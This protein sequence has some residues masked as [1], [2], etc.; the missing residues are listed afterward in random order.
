MPL[1]KQLTFAVMVLSNTC[2]ALAL[3]SRI[4]LQD[5]GDQCNECMLA[6]MLVGKPGSLPAGSNCLFSSACQQARPVDEYSGDGV[7]CAD[8]HTLE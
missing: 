5:I 6:C 2:E 3:T 7:P 1:I 4:A 8:L